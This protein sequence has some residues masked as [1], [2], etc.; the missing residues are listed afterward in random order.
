MI[1][2]IDKSKSYQLPQIVYSRLG[3]LKIFEE[4]GR[5]D[6]EQI[7]K[8]VPARTRKRFLVRLGA[9]TGGNQRQ[10]P[11]KSF[12]RILMQFLPKLKKLV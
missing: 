7:A 1:N 6:F 11:Q 3:V 10:G 4:R 8:S 5:S 12:S 9:K 2:L